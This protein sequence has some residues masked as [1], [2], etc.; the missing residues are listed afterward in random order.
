MPNTL[1]EWLN[2]IFTV[3]FIIFMAGAFLFLVFMIAASYAIAFKQEKRYKRAL[4]SILKNNSKSENNLYDY[5]DSVN[6]EYNT[7]KSSRLIFKSKKKTD[8]NNELTSAL[9]NGEYLKYSNK[10]KID[11]SE[12]LAQLLQKINSSITLIESG[13]YANKIEEKLGLIENLESIELE[14]M[15]NEI[16][17]DFTSFV[18]F[19]EGRLFEKDIRI[20]NLEN[21]KN[22]ILKKKK[23]AFTFAIIGFIGSIITIVTF[24]TG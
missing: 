18:K 24:L 13:D 7:Y 4:I 2:T 15:L 12:N 6:N 10:E 22:S 20:T 8:L 11:N 3:V 16:K 1:I 21:E 17:I 5:I 23:W 19:M 9:R 14:K